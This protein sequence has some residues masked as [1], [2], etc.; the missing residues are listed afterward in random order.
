[1]K[2]PAFLA[3]N[4]LLR[5]HCNSSFRPSPSSI[6]HTAHKHHVVMSFITH[7]HRFCLN[8]EV[9]MLAHIA[10]RKHK[11][12]SVPAT[13]HAK[14]MPHSRCISAGRLSIRR[15]NALCHDLTRMS[16]SEWT[17]ELSWIGQQFAHGEVSWTDWDAA[18]MR[19]SV[20]NV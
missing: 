16:P 17:S 11:Q 7:Q 15:D 20:S 2:N 8:L 1:M 5:R 18:P 10:Q 19:D 3:R 9:V 4:Q 13:S 14:P 12:R 6:F